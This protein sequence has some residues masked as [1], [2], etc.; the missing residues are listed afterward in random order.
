[1]GWGLDARWSAFAAEHGWPIGVDRRHPG[2]PPAARRGRLPARRGDRRGRGVPRR[3]RLRHPR[4]RPARRCAEYRRRC[5]M[6]VAI[7]AEYYPRAADPALGVWAHRQALA[8]RDAGADVEVARPA[9]AGAVEGGAARRATLRQLLAPLR[10][11]LRTELDGIEVTYVPFVAPPRPRSYAS[12]GRVGGAVARA[13]AARRRRRSTSSTRTTPRPRATRCGAR[14]SACRSWSA[15]TAATCSAVAD[16]VARRPRGGRARARRG[17][18]RRSPTRRRSRARSRALGAR[19]VRVVHLGTD[20]PEH[21]RTDGTDARHRR[22]PDRP[23]APRRRPAR[24][25]AAARRAS[26]RCA[27]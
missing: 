20:V 6:R 1:M 26:R 27:G 14:G 7:V 24:A 22:Q 17:A 15:S 21:A 13:R 10:Q 8:A 25:L 19:D 16:A 9:P 3:P 18:A 5:M 23:Q 11:P 4:R 12:L 2:P